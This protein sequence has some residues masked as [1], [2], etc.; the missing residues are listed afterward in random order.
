ME[1]NPEYGLCY[2]K[3]IELHESTGELRE[4]K[5]RQIRQ[6]WV[7]D[8]LL[9]HDFIP[10]ISHLG[11][12][13]IFIE[14]GGYDENLWLE[15][16]DMWL[17]IANKYQIGYINQ[18]LG[19]WRLHDSNNSKKILKMIEAEDFTLNKWKNHK[20]YKKARTYREIYW[21][22]ILALN[23]KKEAMKYL[24]TALK[25]PLKSRSIKGFFRLLTWR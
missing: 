24:I 11:K 5:V 19:I 22:N 3:M 8:E 4:Q 10:L 20:N 15:D 7:F 13:E 12:K 18:P 9:K 25:N 1:K 21:F 2:G 17:R 23:Y 16:W 14:V 6:G